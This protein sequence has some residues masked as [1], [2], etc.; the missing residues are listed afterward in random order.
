MIKLSGRV[1]HIAV[2]FLITVLFLSLPQTVIA[3]EETGSIRLSYQIEGAEFAL[4]HIANISEYGEITLTDD[5]SNYGV[6][7]ESENSAL[8]LAAY[9]TND[10]IKPLA[11]AETN[12]DYIANFENLNQGIYLILGSTKVVDDVRY[13]ALPVMVSLP[14]EDTDGALIWDLEVNAK[15]EKLPLDG[16]TEISVLKIWKD[17]VNQNSRPKEISIDLSKDG[18]KYD[19][20]VLN[21]DNNWKHTWEN[22]DKGSQWL[23]TE[24]VVPEGYEVNIQQ[25]G[26]SFVVTNTYKKVDTPTNPSVPKL[27]QTGQLWWPVYV[28]VFT[29]LCF[30]IVGVNRRRKNV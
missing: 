2:L 16:D 22:L 4:Y 21:A 14:F 15:Y 17:E 1:K 30:I 10:N 8:T 28:L 18:K 6:D 12:E 7:L 27:P 19:T 11:T 9:I 20:V 24:S 23:V 3:T 5:Y 13:T 29:G 25:N 26:N